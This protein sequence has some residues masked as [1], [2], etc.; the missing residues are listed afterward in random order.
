MYICVYACIQI[1]VC[2]Y[3]HIHPYT[4]TCT[5]TSSKSVNEKIWR[6]RVTS[7]KEWNRQLQ[8]PIS[9]QKHGTRSKNCQNQLCPNSGRNQ[10]FTETKHNLNY[11]KVNLKIVK[12]HCDI[13]TFSFSKL[14]Q[15]SDTPEDNS[16]HSKCE[17]MILDS[18]GSRAY[19]TRE[20]LSVSFLTHQEILEKLTKGVHLCFT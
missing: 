9:P 8:T 20:E 12:K 14:S 15:L 1:G 2:V 17:T 18:K 5:H 10:R 19:L 11:E 16:L 4:N 7:A 3:L 6:E 13:L